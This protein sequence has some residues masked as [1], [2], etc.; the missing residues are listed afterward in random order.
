MLLEGSYDSIDSSDIVNMAAMIPH[1]EVAICPQG[2]H[3]E[4]QDDP[5]YYY[6]PLLKF[7]EEVSKVYKLGVLTLARA[8]AWSITELHKVVSPGGL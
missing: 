8:V 2:S 4:S 3:M 1:A 6:P 7:L 5:A